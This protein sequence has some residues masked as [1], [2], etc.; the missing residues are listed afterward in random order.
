MGCR[1]RGPALTRP[2][3]AELLIERR[4]ARHGA[5]AGRWPAPAAAGR[6]PDHRRLPAWRK[7]SQP[8]WAVWPRRC[9]ARDCASSK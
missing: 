4:D 7:S 6:L 2:D 8:T 1:L 9:R 5:G 3:A